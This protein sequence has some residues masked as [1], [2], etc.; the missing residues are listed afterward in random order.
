MNT[1]GTEQTWHLDW[2]ATPKARWDRFMAEAGAALQ[3][4]WAFGT[5]ME[6]HGSGLLRVEVR[7]PPTS[8]PKGVGSK[9]RSLRP[10]KTVAMAQFTVRDVAGLAHWALCT[11]G[12]VWAAD[13]SADER[14][15]I[16]RAMK[17][18]APLRRVRAM[19][20]TPDVAPGT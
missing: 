7:R 18:E 13:V 8:Q 9:R 5:A 3:Q 11:R 2:N 19:F 1:T 17:R 14:A 15:A 16:F 10:G 20:F 6:A 4:D 12:P